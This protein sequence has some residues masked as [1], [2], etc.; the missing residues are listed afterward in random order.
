MRG[1]D[2]ARLTDGLPDPVV[3]R[4]DWPFERCDPAD[5]A[6]MACSDDDEDD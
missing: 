1:M 2:R 5:H 3:I 4:Q 6:G